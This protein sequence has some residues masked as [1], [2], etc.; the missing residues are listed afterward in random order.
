MT[1]PA[2][3]YM[4][5]NRD[6]D[7][8]TK[9]LG[10][11]VADGGDLRF[12]RASTTE[13][14]TF[15]EMTGPAWLDSV[16]S[17][18]QASGGTTAYAALFI[19]GY[20]IT[21]DE[22]GNFFSTYFSNIVQPGGYTGVLIGFD[23][24]SDAVGSSQPLA[25][26]R[27]KEIARKT[28]KESFPRL[29]SVLESIKG[30]PNLQVSLAVMC[31][32]MGNYVMQQGAGNLGSTQLIDQ[33]LLIGAELEDN[34]FN[35]ESSKTYCAD[36]VAIA[37]AVTIYY[38]SHDDMLPEA[39]VLD[40]Y[41]ELG[42]RGPTYDGT[43]LPRTIGLD[44]SLVVNMANATTYEVGQDPILTHTSYFFIPET[45]LDIGATLVGGSSPYRYL[46]RGTTGFTMKADP[47][48][49]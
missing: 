22:A 44:C 33:V 30:T 25:F 14:S 38:S 15:V 41:H 40:G 31:H 19:H 27:G 49:G 17:D 20:S 8:T 13:G 23:W 5:S 29:Y 11:K 3:Y 26:A 35:S 24:P 7:I 4:I 45:L 43:L 9:K 2:Y 37:G 34:G 46:S 39:A 28:G 21:W 48:G 16:Q 18:L 47:S 36:I 6:Y 42:V 12:F 32:S 10:T 1:V